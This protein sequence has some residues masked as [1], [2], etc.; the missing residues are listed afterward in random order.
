MEVNKRNSMKVQLYLSSRL[1]LAI[2][3]E[4]GFHVGHN[5]Q[6]AEDVAR[7]EW[8]KKSSRCNGHERSKDGSEGDLRKDLSSKGGGKQVKEYPKLPIS[9]GGEM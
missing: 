9:R 5:M 7:L 2:D 8:Y 6:P 1:D 4:A 3:T